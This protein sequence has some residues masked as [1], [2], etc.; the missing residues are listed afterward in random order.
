MMPLVVAHAAVVQRNQIVDPVEPE[1]VQDLAP[2]GTLR[3]AINFGNT[4]LAQKDAATGE[5][6]G[7]SIELARGVGRRLET[8]VELVPFDAAG[9]VFAALKT[10]AW[11]I[12]FLA[13]DPARA[14]EIAFTA[15]YVL[16]EGTY[17]VR[18]DSPLKA[19]EDVDREGV[20]VA[21]GRNAA[22]DLYLTR[23][24]KHAQVIRVPSPSAA[25]EL[26]TSSRRSPA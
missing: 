9:K 5:A 6:G 7:V 23:T 4:V 21:V 25:V 10:G 12:A 3:A 26:P 14:T 2:T 19:V 13:I 15:P 11:D 17:L 20:R 16:I 18:A 24:L 8:P 22:Y 1:I